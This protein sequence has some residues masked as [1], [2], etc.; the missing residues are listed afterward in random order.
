MEIMETLRS[1]KAQALRN[2]QNSIVKKSITNVA[3]VLAFYWRILKRVE[4]LF[5]AYKFKRQ[6]VLFKFC[7]FLYFFIL[8]IQF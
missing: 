3:T 8:T 4:N 2:L 7:I 5:F 6:H 1:E